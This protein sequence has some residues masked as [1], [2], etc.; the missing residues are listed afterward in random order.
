[1]PS[2]WCQT[3]LLLSLLIACPVAAAAQQADDS[4]QFKVSGYAEVYVQYDF[5]R[6]DDHQRPSFVYS[7][8]RTGEVNVNLALARL[9]YTS[10]R[11][12]GSL[13][14][15]AGTY[16]NANYA[17]EPGVL[18]NLY[19]VSLGFKPFPNTNFWID[20]GVLPS[21]IGWESA[22]SRDCW[23]LTRSMAADNSPYFETGVRMAY[24]SPNEKWLISLLALNGWQRIQRPD[25]NSTPAFGHQLTYQPNERVTLN[26]SSFVG[27]DTPDSLRRMR[28]FHDLYGIFALTD[29]LSLM[30]GFDI[31]WQQV[32]KGSSD[33]DT[34]YTP[35]ISMQ[36][37]IR[38][39]LRMAVR[40]E[41]YS[42]PSAVIITSAY[43]TG[44]GTFAASVNL[45]VDIGRHLVW[46]IEA[47][48]LKGKEGTFDNDG[49]PSAQNGLVVTSLA[50]AF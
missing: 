37:R 50:L 22:I 8:N 11:V 31:G 13:A 19:E 48:G 18:R 34:W 36:Y 4:S 45:D 7:H 12:R 35:V 23:H 40:A 32:S 30:A 25:G 10:S 44:F 17:A 49:K 14:L 26:S 41:Y 6:P 9:S 3:K 2:R 16:M 29:K 43:T 20:A 21:H 27:S 1:M 28:L 33:Y 15:A 39:S 24:R 5:A 47:K 46:R 42:D 38:P